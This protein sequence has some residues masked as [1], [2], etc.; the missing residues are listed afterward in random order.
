M[1]HARRKRQLSE[2]LDGALDGRARVRVEQ[3]LERCA[4]CRS[5]L[6]ELRG[7]VLLLRS[8]AAEEE[9]S[10]FLATRV[11]A[12]IEAGDAAPTWADRARA[13][14]ATLAS[15]AWTP[16]LGAA[17]V[18]FVVA[19]ALDLRIEVTLP[20]A[21]PQ[22]SFAAVARPAAPPPPVS[23]DEPIQLVASPSM[24]VRSAR[25]FDPVVLEEVSGVQRACSARPHDSECQSFRNKLVAVAIA[26]PRGFVR[27]IESVPPE[28]RDRVLAAV[29]S[30][31]A[32]TGHAQRVIY[33]LRRVD[34]PRA[35]G[36]VVRF[37]RTIA[38]RE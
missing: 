29:S 22:P 6:A 30:E 27:E 16:A 19:A 7:T 31:A 13:G 1:M 11:I 12:R 36:I 21:Q 34:D 2:Y 9:P 15:G 38:S 14:L 33:G 4:E 17:A 26:D 35:V 32:R 25:R 8:L 24:P 28:S 18:V 23:F 37:Q 5:E 10:E 3:H 20:G